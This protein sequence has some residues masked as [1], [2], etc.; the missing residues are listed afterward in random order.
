[1]ATKK[2]E[3]AAPAKLPPLWDRLKAQIDWYDRKDTATGAP[4]RLRRSPL[5]FLPSP[6][7]SL[8][9]G[10]RSPWASPPVSSCCSWP[11]AFQQWQENWILYR[12]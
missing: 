5:W 11:P 3:R 9:N 4:I 2:A 6:C 8:P 1:M 7:R 10:A 12:S